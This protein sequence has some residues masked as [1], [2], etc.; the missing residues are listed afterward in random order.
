MQECKPLGGGA[1][2]ADPEGGGALVRDMLA[3]KQESEQAVAANAA[4]DP[5][6]PKVG[7]CRLKASKP[8]LKA[9]M[10]SALD[11]KR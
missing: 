6:A 1:A 3:A 5:D 7:R 2:A 11:T 10:V 4:I 8:V 9:H